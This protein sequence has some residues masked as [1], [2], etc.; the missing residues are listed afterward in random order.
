MTASPPVAGKERAGPESG[1]SQNTVVIAGLW[2]SLPYDYLVKVSGK[3]DV[4]ADL[5]DRFPAPLDH[6]AA[7]YLLLRTLRLNCLTRDYAPVWGELYDDGFAVDDWTPPFADWPTLGVPDWNWTM[8]TPL[9]SDYE[10]RAALVEIDALAALML[11][12]SADHLALMFRAQFPVLRKYEYEMYFDNS[13][14]KIAKDHH[15][16]GVKQ[17][18]DDYRL[19]QAYLNG[20]DCGD[21]LDR[22]EPHPDGGV[23]RARG[24]VC[25][26]REAEMR[27]AY[28]EF[29]RRLGL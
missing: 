16:Q 26:D 13:G 11:G 22:Y 14:R 20:E 24:F 29:T 7:P 3:S 4:H 25:P 17:R 10:R 5:I 23:D 19:L 15:A 12:L 8:Q 18:K 27:A 28:A 21:L 2:S 9:R 1:N 6:P